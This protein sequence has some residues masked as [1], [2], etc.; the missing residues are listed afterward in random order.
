[1]VPSF[2]CTVPSLLCCEDKNSIFCDEVDFGALGE[3]FEPISHHLNHQ[4]NNQNQRFDSEE[5]SNGLPTQSDELLS[6]MV[7]R[8][9][10]HMPASDYLKRL[11]NGD[12][13]LEARSEAID[14]IGKMDHLGLV[15]WVIEWIGKVHAYFNFGPL[16]A[17]LAI[18]YLDSS[19][20]QYR[21]VTRY[22]DPEFN[23]GIDSLEFK[24]SEVAAAVAVTIS[25]A[26][27]TQTLD[28]EKAI[29]L[30]V[31]HVEKKRVLKCFE[32]IH[33]T[34]LISASVPTLPLSP[35]GVLDA[36]ACLSYKT[37]DTTVESCTNYSHNGPDPKRRKLNRPCE[38]E[39]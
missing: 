11:R 32:M 13:D 3:K 26:G 28:P 27:D 36:A 12:L 29:S 15:L 4:S 10:E 19:Y 34:T 17:Y 18:S 7:E 30:L 1:M 16:C 9:C 33:E 38:V 35:I 21:Y 6:L 39:I 14:W 5:A 37:D 22:R 24:P 23:A 8:E 31:Q 2:D 25:V 20:N